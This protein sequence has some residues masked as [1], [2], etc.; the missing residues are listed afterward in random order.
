MGEVIRYAVR[1]TE[2]ET[3]LVKSQTRPGVPTYGPGA[4]VRLSWRAEDVLT[5]T[6][7]EEGQA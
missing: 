1:V 4:S 2:R 3:L 7:E 6:D 5:F